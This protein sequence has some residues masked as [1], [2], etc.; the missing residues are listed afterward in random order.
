VV[1]KSISLWDIVQCSPL[2][3][4]RRFGGTYS[5]HLQGRISRERYQRENRW[6]RP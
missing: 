2:K 4:N 6:Q 3:A 5:L 1:M